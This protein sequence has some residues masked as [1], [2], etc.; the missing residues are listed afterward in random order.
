MFSANC[1]GLKGRRSNLKAE[2][3]ENVLLVNEQCRTRN[4][5]EY[6]TGGAK[7]NHQYFC[8]Y[9]LIY[10][11]FRFGNMKLNLLHQKLQKEDDSLFGE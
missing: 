11:D 8:F 9:H 5:N 1:I 7:T 3:I 2:N 10:N 4:T 6:R